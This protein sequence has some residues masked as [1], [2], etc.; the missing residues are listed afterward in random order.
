MNFQKQEEPNQFP[1][2]VTKLEK[3]LFYDNLQLK[4]DA[5]WDDRKSPFGEMHR[6]VVNYFLSDDTIQIIEFRKGE[7]PVTFYKRLK[8]PKVK[9]VYLKNP[10]SKLYSNLLNPRELK[11]S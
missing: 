5:Y 7:K 3:F 6:L 9:N 8:L 11:M 2:E 1:K 4:F 10:L